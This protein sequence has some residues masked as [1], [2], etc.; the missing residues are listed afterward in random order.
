MHV[1]RLLLQTFQYLITFHLFHMYGHC[2]YIVIWNNLF[3]I[4]LLRLLGASIAFL[5]TGF[6]VDW[7]MNLMLLA[8]KSLFFVK[9][10]C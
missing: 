8:K 6:A 2:L 3:G 7:F 5:K 1:M 10:I 9:L 4:E